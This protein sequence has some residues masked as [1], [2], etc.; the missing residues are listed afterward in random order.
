MS[1]M[2]ACRW[3]MESLILLIL[4]RLAYGKSK[5]VRSSFYTGELFTKLYWLD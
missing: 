3:L 2:T 4:L 1:L 5:F